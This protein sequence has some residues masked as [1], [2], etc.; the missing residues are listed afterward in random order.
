MKLKKFWKNMNTRRDI[1]EIIALFRTNKLDKLDKNIGS[2]WNNNCLYISPPALKIFCNLN[3]AAILY[4]VIISSYFFLFC[5]MGDHLSVIFW[6]RSRQL[7]SDFHK[8]QDCPTFY[9]TQLFLGGYMVFLSSGCDYFAFL[10][11]NAL[12]LLLWR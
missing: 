1:N 12:F 7:L 9:S 2:V 6:N 5:I 4:H 3:L 8:M 11:S 10:F